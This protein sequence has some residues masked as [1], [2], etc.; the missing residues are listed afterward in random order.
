MRKII[1]TSIG[2]LLLTVDAFALD[3]LGPPAATKNKEEPIAGM[4]Y[5]YSEMDLQAGSLTIETPLGSFQLPAAEIKAIQ[6]NK[7][8]VNLVSTLG[9][10]YDIF[11]RLGLTDASPDE[12]KNQDNFAGIIGDSDFGLTFGGGFRTTLHQSRDGKTKWGLLGQFSYASLDF[13]EKTY[14][15]NG[16]N[17]SLSA[18][19]D[20]FEIQFA[21]GPTYQVTNKISIYGGPFL[22]FVKGD[23]EFRGSVS[24]IPVQGSSDLEQESE[25]GGFIG[26]TTDLAKNT[27][28]N[29]EFQVADD[30]R[31]V[32]FRFIH[33]F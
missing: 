12:S 14:S 3:P 7:L 8:Y 33:R 9:E 11:L 21:A 16:S 13:D 4:E 18:N 1:F 29:I 10:N 15:V 20:M 24:D 26:L 5:L 31:A 30:A 32:G 2:L 25:L 23:V 22:H 17:V 27:K 28:F 6:M 19:V